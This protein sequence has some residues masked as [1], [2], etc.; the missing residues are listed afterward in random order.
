MLLAEILLVAEV[1]EDDGL[2]TFSQLRILRDG[3]SDADVRELLLAHLFPVATQVHGH[4]PPAREVT[5]PRHDW[6]SPTSIRKV[7]P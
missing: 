3:V 1:G 2:G 7:V 5:R 6:R 4:F